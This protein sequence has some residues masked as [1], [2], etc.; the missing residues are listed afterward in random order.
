[1]QVKDLIIQ[2]STVEIKVIRI[3]KSKMTLSVFNQIHQEPIFDKNINLKGK[4]LG[5]INKDG[6]YCL[7]VKNGELRKTPFRKPIQIKVF[8]NERGYSWVSSWDLERLSKTLNLLCDDVLQYYSS[9]NVAHE[10]DYKDYL[11]TDLMNKYYSLYQDIQAY[12]L[13]IAI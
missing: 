9:E 7:W 8:Q 12:Q 1:M 13:Y 4:I 3:G 11:N 5:Y 10:Y 2:T 6:V